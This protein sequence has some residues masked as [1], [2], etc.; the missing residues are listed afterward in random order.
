MV[1]LYCLQKGKNPTF[2][3]RK[4]SFLFRMRKLCHP[5]HEKATAGIFLPFQTL[6]SI[7]LIV[8]ND[9]NEIPDSFLAPVS[10]PVQSNWHL[11]GLNRIGFD[12]F[13]LDE[14]SISFIFI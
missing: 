6:I 5:P 4:N 14:F 13:V 1:L 9:N 3:L 12:P 8:R 11:R 10:N 7:F 2:S